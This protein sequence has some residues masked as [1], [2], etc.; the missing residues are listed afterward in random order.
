MPR[1]KNPESVLKPNQ[2]KKS[3]CRKYNP[4]IGSLF[5]HMWSFIY[6]PFSSFSWKGYLKLPKRLLGKWIILPGMPRQKNS[7]SVLKPNQNKNSAWRKY[8]WGPILGSLSQHMWSFIYY[9]FSSFS[10]KSDLMLPKNLLGKW[11]ILPGMAKQ[12]NPGSVLKPNEN[13]KSAWSKYIRGRH[14]PI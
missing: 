3:A 11:K 9:P 14:N 7:G 5:K 12:K 4:I 13:K 8:I 1:Q 10:W 2:N 6:Y